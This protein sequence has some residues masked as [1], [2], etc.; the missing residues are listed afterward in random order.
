[1]LPGDGPINDALA[2]LKNPGS[3]AARLKAE[4]A[5]AD[6]AKAAKAAAAKPEAKPD[7]RST[8]GGG[9]PEATPAPVPAK[10]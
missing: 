1:V 7:R 9:K 6:A 3:V 4:A 10:P 8:E 5:K 2:E